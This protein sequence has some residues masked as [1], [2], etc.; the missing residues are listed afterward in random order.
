MQFNWKKLRRYSEA[1][2]IVG[3]LPMFYLPFVIVWSTY[4]HID[5]YEDYKECVFFA[6]NFDKDMKA[7][8]KGEY[9]D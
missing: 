8:K 2:L 7:R 1:Y 4:V 9:V 5:K 3:W 6:E